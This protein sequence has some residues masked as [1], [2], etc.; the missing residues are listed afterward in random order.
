LTQPL[1]RA[2]KLR[3]RFANTRVKTSPAVLVND[4]HSGLN[5]TR[6]AGMICPEITDEVDEKKL[7]KRS[8]SRAA[9]ILAK[10]ARPRF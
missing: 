1:I 4:V 10:M 6:V 3:E 8:S 5:P 7:T 9:T 2:E